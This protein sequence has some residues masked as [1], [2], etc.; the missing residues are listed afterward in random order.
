MTMADEQFVPWTK[1]F[2]LFWDLDGFVRKGG[3][4]P[5]QRAELAQKFGVSEDLLLRYERVALVYLPSVHAKQKSQARVEAA[6]VMGTLG[7][8]IDTDADLFFAEVWKAYARIKAEAPEDEL[9]REY[10]AARAALTA[11]VNAS[12]SPSEK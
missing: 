6:R 3:M 4:T 1:E 10:E 5:E 2:T 9:T 11:A 7:K 8:K 12:I